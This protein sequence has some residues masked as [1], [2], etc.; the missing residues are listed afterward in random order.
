MKNYEKYFGSESQIIDDENLKKKKDQEQNDEEKYLSNFNI[1][2]LYQVFIKK[3]SFHF[4]S[5]K[6]KN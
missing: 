3:L 1:R 4:F 5:I 2:K 6:S